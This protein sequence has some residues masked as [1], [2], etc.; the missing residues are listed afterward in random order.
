MFWRVIKYSDGCDGSGAA[1]YVFISSK[2]L[3][4]THASGGDIRLTYYHATYTIKAANSI[5]FLSSLI[6]DPDKKCGKQIVR[7]DSKR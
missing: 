1:F 3:Y 4:K 7:D 5:T 2:T 6:P